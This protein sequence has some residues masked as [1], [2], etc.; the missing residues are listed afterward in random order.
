[1]LPIAEIIR[2]SWNTYI[3]KLKKYLPLI[4]LMFGFS[5]LNSITSIIFT[6]ILRWPQIFSALAAA[7]ASSVFYLLT[8]A[9]TIYIIVY[10]DR[11]LDD[12]K[13]VFRFRECLAVYWPALYI[14]ILVGLITVGGFILVIIPGAIF[15]V[16]FAFAI[17]LAILEKKRGVSTLLKDSRELSRGKFWPIFG[18][19]VLPTVFWTIIAY[20]VLAGL[21]NLLGIIFNKSLS[22]ASDLP[23]SLMLTT[24]I[25]SNLAA[26]FFSVLPIIAATI[27]YKE[28]RK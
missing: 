22:T 10:T 24:L 11:F 13:I 8:F 14:S 27:V 20:L 5:L 6:D 1:M 21:L 15:T 7:G 26:S 16:W 19:L 9:V 4:G 2:L 18:R 12:K 17:Y 28:V 23:L 3:S 25:I